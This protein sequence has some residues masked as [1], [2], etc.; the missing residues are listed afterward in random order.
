M[1]LLNFTVEEISKVDYL[2]EKSEWV[3]K[4]V[5]VYSVADPVAHLLSEGNL[6]IKK[7]KYD[8]ITFS[9]GRIEI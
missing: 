4:N 5:G 8:G 1:Y 7:H 6:I 3:K 2:Y 9:V